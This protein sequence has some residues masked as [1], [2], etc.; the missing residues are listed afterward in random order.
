MLT[1]II[2]TGWMIDV[3]N[4]PE[5]PPITNGWIESKNLS[6]EDFWVAILKKEVFKK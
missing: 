1:F 6:V 5:K 3:A 4:I 2:S